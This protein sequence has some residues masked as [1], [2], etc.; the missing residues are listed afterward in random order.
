[1]VE[2]ETE[3]A[4]TDGRS[5]FDEVFI[6]W[7][8]LR[9]GKTV[10]QK[11]QAVYDAVPDELA[12]LNGSPVEEPP[13]TKD[14][15]EDKMID[16]YADWQ[17]WKETRLEAQARAVPATYITALTNR[18]NKAWDDYAAAINAWRLA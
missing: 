6:P 18:E 12:V 5:R 16:L 14:V 2:I 15:L 1:M 7:I 3:N 13:Q 17:R 4:Y 9:G 10:E 11:Q 8:Q